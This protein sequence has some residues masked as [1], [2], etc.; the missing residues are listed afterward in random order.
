MFNSIDLTKPVLYIC[1]N[2]FIKFMYEVP[3]FI[4]ERIFNSLDKTKKKE[5]C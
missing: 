4:A 3:I 5:E 2:N 1:Q